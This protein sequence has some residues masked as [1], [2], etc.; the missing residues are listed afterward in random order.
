MIRIIFLLTIFL[1]NK[2]IASEYS[3]INDFKIEYKNDYIKNISAKNEDES[4]NAIIEI[5]SGT[6][7][8]WEISDDYK[9]LELEFKNGYPRIIKYLGYPANYGFIPNTKLRLDEGGDGDAIDVLVMND[10]PIEKGERVKIKVIGM[11][12]LLDKNKID[13]KIISVKVGS[14]FEKINSLRTLENE[15]SGILEIFSI[16]FQNYKGEKIKILGFEEKKKA[17]KF[18]EKFVQ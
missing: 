8:K 1:I 9:Y 10:L 14:I 13:H 4:Y 2:S 5:P 16:W 3:Y 6:N 11:L 12:K 15:H 7:Q 18:I 17:K